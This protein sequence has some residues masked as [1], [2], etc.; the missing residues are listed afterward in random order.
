MKF[1]TIPLWTADRPTVAVPS[2]SAFPFPIPGLSA[3]YVYG[4]LT[5]N[6]LEM[7][8]AQAVEIW[9][10][11][12]LWQVTINFP[13][14]GLSPGPV[15]FN[16]ERS[17]IYPSG[18]NPI[19]YDERDLIYPECSWIGSIAVPTELDPDNVISAGIY[20]MPREGRIFEGQEV[21]HSYFLPESDLPPESRLMSP[22]LVVTYGG[23]YYDGNPFAAVSLPFDYPPPPDGLDEVVG[24]FAGQSLTMR[25]VY[26]L[27]ANSFSFTPI[28]WYTWAEADGSNPTWNSSNGNRI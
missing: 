14:D 9:W 19:N 28:E 22:T 12:R 18:P 21:L 25:H 3:Q 11:V 16:L 23:I 8:L 6:P 10:R 15:T 20:F 1:T 7:T 2:T 27:R 13:L 17:A 26:L 24:T 5:L 4:Q